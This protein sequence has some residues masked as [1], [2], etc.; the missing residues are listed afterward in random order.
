MRVEQRMPVS[1]A[2]LGGPAR[3][4][5]D[6]GEEHCGENP[7]VGHFCLVPGEEL[8]DLLKRRAPRFNEVVQVA[9]WK[10]N[11]FRARYMVSDILALRG[12]DH[13]VGRCA[14]EQGLARGLSEGPPAHSIRPRTAA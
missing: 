7:I 9:P 1:V 14:V 8:V 4:V 2:D 3:R 10:L 11:V 12:H 6:V 5:H 13:R